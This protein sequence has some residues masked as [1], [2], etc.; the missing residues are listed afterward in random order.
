MF[1]KENAKNMDRQDAY[2]T[3][4]F[5]VIIARMATTSQMLASA[6]QHHQSGRLDQAEQ[7]YRQILQTDPNQADAWHLLG[8]AASQAGRHD[9]AADCINRAIAL[10]PKAA[11]FYGNLG[12]VYTSLGKLEDAVNVFQQA[13]RLK[14]D[15]V[16]AQLNLGI[17]LRDQGQLE[18]AL[19]SFQQALRQQ[20]QNPIAHNN[21][22]VVYREQGKLE[23]A[24]D[25]YRRALQWNPNFADAYNNLANAL[26]DLGR[27]EESIVSYQQAI[28][29]K[30]DYAEAHL[31]LA[32]A[33]LL[34]GRL[35]EGWA[36]YEWRFVCRRPELPE[37]PQPRWDGSPLNGRTIV[38]YGEQGF[39]DKLQFM[40]YAPLVKARGGRVVV[41]CNKA[42]LPIL[43]RC[44]GID[45]FVPVPDGKLPAFDV[46]SPL[47][48]LP[49]I[50]GTT[51]E[52]IPA[53]IPYL[54]ADPELVQAWKQKLNGTAKFKVGIVW[55]GSK[56]SKGGRG[57]TI[58]LQHFAPLGK[59]PGIQLYS[60]QCGAGTE[61]LAAMQ[62]QLQIDDFEGRLDTVTGPFMDTAAVMRNLD[63]VI[64]AD[65]SI[66]HLAGG[67]GVPVWVAVP[68][69]PDWRWFGDFKTTAWYP[70][71]RLFRQERMGDWDGVF[72]RIAEELKLQAGNRPPTE[73]PQL[74]SASRAERAIPN[75]VAGASSIFV[76]TSIGEVVDKITILEIKS[77]RI[78]DP[79]KLANVRRELETLTTAFAPV[80]AAATGS[81]GLQLDGFIAQLKAVNEALW[82]IEDDIRDCE[83]DQD[84]S[85]KF[86]EL[87]RS[88]YHQNDQRAALKRQINQLLG[89][90]LVEEK[91]YKNYAP[92]S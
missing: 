58:A 16:E 69:V 65:T 75:A 44:A 31:S 72:E 24:V 66:G 35:K 27:I 32:T 76:E 5:L 71:M 85:T 80:R 68:F 86:V 48:S 51:L 4:I 90:R 39:G 15:F 1:A 45:E 78:D 79:A 7:L 89:S 42:L 47:L 67:L 28:R 57:R 81:G 49:G 74:L 63:L 40:R 91:S 18:S 43:S 20:P 22:G 73:G 84:F 77:A 55:Q 83:R 29:L 54:F 2:P 64:T 13:L 62:G 60:L 61:E 9:A 46:Y 12:N 25:S 82:Q 53:E 59:V 8:V 11:A 34:T 52:T 92:V 33:L 3:L 38:L 70:T 41:A 23:A 30:P 37:F 26:N 10:N 87:A 50:L 36:E 17:A 56:Y 14:P 88:V 21:L 6:V 19:A